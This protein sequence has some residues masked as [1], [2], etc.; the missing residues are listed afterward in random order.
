MA[1]VPLALLPAPIAILFWLWA[2]ASLVILGVRAVRRITNRSASTVAEPAAPVVP[3]VPAIVRPPTGAPPSSSMAP[4]V[5]ATSPTPTESTASTDPIDPTDPTSPTSP[6]NVTA[7]IWSAA[8]MAAPSTGRSGLFAAA[9]DEG[10]PAALPVG[11]DRP[12]VAEALRGIAM[13][14][15]LSPVIDGRVSIPNPFRVAFLTTE[16]DAAS[17]GAA[18]GD[19]LERLGYSLATVA[20]TELVARRPG[21]ELRLVLYPTPAAARRGLDVLFPAAPAGAVGIEL[22]T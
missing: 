12:T 7:P 17:V 15:G 1:T 22:S 8:P 10:A 9:P 21:A 14:C 6:T 13:P 4:A 16:A 18:M 19:E 2:L 3:V 5:D 20:P 11:A